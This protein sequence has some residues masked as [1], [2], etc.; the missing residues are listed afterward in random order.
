MPIIS[1]PGDYCRTNQSII[2]GCSGKGRPT[3]EAA[4]CLYGAE[5]CPNPKCKGFKAEGKSKCA[6]CG[7]D[8][9]DEDI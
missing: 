3:C 5:P 1:K 4:E 7:Y 8:P 6:W 9:M 2:A